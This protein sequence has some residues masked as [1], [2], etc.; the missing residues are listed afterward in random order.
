MKINISY[1]S[2]GCQKV[3]EVDD[4]RKLR[5]FYDK[6]MSQEVEGDV[7]GDDFKGYIFRISGGNDKEG[8]PMKQGILTT[9]RVRIL[10]SE[11]HSCFRAR[12]KGERK[13]KSIRGCIVSSAL[14]VLNLVIVKKGE[15]EIPGLTDQTKPRRLGPKR[16]SR[17]RKLF[18]LTKDDDVRQY[19]VRRQIVKD[20]KK[21]H[22]KAPKIQ[23]LVTPQRLQHKRQLLA[24]KRK[25]WEKSTREAKEYNEILA[26]YLKEKRDQ[27]LARKRSASRRESSR[28]ESSRRES[29]KD[30]AAPTSEKKQATEK[31]TEKKQEKKASTAQPK[32]KD[33]KKG[34]DKKAGEKKSEK[35]GAQKPQQGKTDQS[36]K[37]TTEKKTQKPK[38]QDQAAPKKDQ[39]ASKKQ[40]QAAPKKDQAAPK[41][42]G[43]A[44]PKKDQAAP[45]KQGQAAPKKDQAAKQQ[46]Q[47][48]EK[49][50][51]HE[52]KQQPEKKQQSEKKQQ[53]E[54]K[55]SKKP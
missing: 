4:D 30:T 24:E 52:K 15:N 39:E 54:K 16:A 9:Q 32:T 28:R 8:F 40:G 33:E 35:K 13:R 19:V 51:Q 45:K 42:Q 49:K 55:A 5:A 48:P 25:R 11:G 20:G 38:K 17:I 41:K 27:K 34:G 22:S 7:L 21:P 10:F 2:T 36:K 14:A 50:Q 18:N 29:S 53:P 1:P 46:P 12:R 6:R 3:I 31:S 26:K 47:Q 44:A 37:Q 43:Q 23:R